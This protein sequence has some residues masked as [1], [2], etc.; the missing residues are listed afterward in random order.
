MTQFHFPEQKQINFLSGNAA[1]GRME[2]IAVSFCLSAALSVCGRLQF[3]P[4]SIIDIFFTTQETAYS[5]TKE[6][7]KKRNI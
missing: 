1:G 7:R 5:H 4:G 6:K 3:I 2:N